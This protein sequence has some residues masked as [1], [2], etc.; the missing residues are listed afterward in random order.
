VLDSLER[1]IG[2]SLVA[3]IS[4]ETGICQIN[5]TPNIETGREWCLKN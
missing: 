2:S 5:E 1:L 3:Q 4:I